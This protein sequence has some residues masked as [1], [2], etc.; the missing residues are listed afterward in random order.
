MVADKESR[1]PG[2]MDGIPESFG[3]IQVVIQAALYSR[4]E[5]ILMK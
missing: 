1:K 2:F 5:F 3:E 4:P